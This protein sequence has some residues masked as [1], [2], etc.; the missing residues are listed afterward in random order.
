M[1]QQWICQN[2]HGRYKRFH[3]TNPGPGTG[4]NP[5]TNPSLPA[6]PTPTA[7]TPVENAVQETATGVRA[8]PTA[9]TDL[10]GV[11]DGL[12][13]STLLPEGHGVTPVLSELGDGVDSLAMSIGAGLGQ[14]GTA[15]DPIG[16]TLTGAEGLLV[17]TGHAVTE[18]GG[19]VQALGSQLGPVGAVTDLTGNLVGGVGQLVTNVGYTA[20]DI[21]TSAL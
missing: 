3:P 18:A 6:Q 17:H 15:E 5:G 2:I 12:L 16:T 21:I 8:L 19:L 1:R 9:L 10:G 14:L 13:T 11:A 7:F 20:G 4:T